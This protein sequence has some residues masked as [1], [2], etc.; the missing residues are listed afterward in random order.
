MGI[1][2]KIK[3]DFTMAKGTKTI[4]VV[5]GKEHSIYGGRK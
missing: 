5:P 2:Y 4:R 3:E 1:S